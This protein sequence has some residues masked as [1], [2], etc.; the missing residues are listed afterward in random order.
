MRKAN[1]NIPEALN[2]LNNS[3]KI[4]LARIVEWDRR[5]LSLT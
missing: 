2:V 5:E 1:T 3:L 4:E